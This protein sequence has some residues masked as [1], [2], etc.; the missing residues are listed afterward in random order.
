[1][2][3]SDR[4]DT[5]MPTSEARVETDRASRYLVQLCRHAGW[6]SRLPGHRPR[7][8]GGGAAPRV[9]HVESSDTHGVVS[10]DGGGFTV[11]AGQ[12]ALLMRVEAADE[13]S[14]RRIQDLL[15]GRVEKIGRRDRLAV[16]WRRT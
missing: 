13:D 4:K 7:A 6:M 11:H 5:R 8:H 12:D 15:A 14:L 9:R 10:L 2:L 16:D 1:M 3:T